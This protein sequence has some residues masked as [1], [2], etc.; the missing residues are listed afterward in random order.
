M[1]L[2]RVRPKRAGIRMNWNAQQKPDFKSAAD[3]SALALPGPGETSP[4]NS[5]GRGNGNGHGMVSSNGTPGAAHRPQ[6]VD[7]WVIAEAVVK[8]W[9][10]LVLGGAV[11]AVAAVALGEMLWRT[12]YT[13]NVRLV[14]QELPAAAE[15]IRERQTPL[16]TL[17]D[18][19]RTPELFRRAGDAARPPMAAE[20]LAAAVVITPERNKESLVIAMNGSSPETAVELANLV[21]GESVKYT[22]EL[23]RQE[24]A[25]LKQHL[26]QQIAAIDSQLRVLSDQLRQPVNEVRSPSDEVRL[27]PAGEPVAADPFSVMTRTMLEEQLRVAHQELATLLGQ[28]TEQN[29]LVKAQRIKTQ[30]LE[31]LYRLQI[32]AGNKRPTNELAAAAPPAGAATGPAKTTPAATVTAT[33]NNLAQL[34][35]DRD[36]AWNRLASLEAA[37]LPLASRQQFLQTF[38]T[39]APGQLQILTPAQTQTVAKNGREV[40]VAGLGVFGAL[41]G[42]VAALAL[43]LLGEATGRRLKTED[44]LRR[45]THL[46]VIATLGNTRKMSAE[47]LDQWAFLT[48]TAMERKMTSPDQGIVCGIISS[49]EGEGRA[50]WTR[51]LA[52]AACQRGHRVLTITADA[53]GYRSTHDSKKKGGATG[54]ST[55]TAN[56]L[57]APEDV[58]HQLIGP[59]AQVIVEISLPQW[60]WNVERRKQLEAALERWRT[61]ENVV[62][63]INL[64]PASDPQSILLA[65][66]VNNLVWLSD[67]GKSDAAST[68]NQV[69]I[70]RQSQ[71]H[72]VGAVLNHAPSRPLRNLFPRWVEA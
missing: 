70:L 42:M 62:I 26:D 51:L 30:Y 46:P 21:A 15:G 13:A 67:S 12:S 27:T 14:R 63:L 36:V 41:F 22:Q 3:Y 54:A 68:R 64:P 2:D 32:V 7:P 6:P 1:G 49:S 34:L 11:G 45:I 29:A 72:L 20:Q 58:S 16:Q 60:S 31:D 61:I 17:A 56:V 71:C 9:Y 8:R 19:L 5:N 24:F 25:P 48:W 47:R 37:R 39:N 53:D 57:A 50:T 52:R 38:L 59:H 44:D 18:M 28:Y 40:K 4:G 69:E 55:V 43:V 65:S 23:Q 10:W 66:Q 35:I 33:T